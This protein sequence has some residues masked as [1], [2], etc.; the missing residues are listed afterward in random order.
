MKQESN[1]SD[2]IKNYIT[3]HYTQINIKYIIIR[4]PSFDNYSA[5][6]I[7]ESS[8]FYFFEFPNLWHTLISEMENSQEAI[9][10]KITKKIKFQL[11]QFSNSEYRRLISILDSEF[12][13]RSNTKKKSKFMDG[14]TIKIYSNNK[15]FFKKYRADVDGDFYK[16]IE[17]IMSKWD[18]LYFN[19]KNEKIIEYESNISKLEVAE[20]KNNRNNT[21]IDVDS[22]DFKLTMESLPHLIDLLLSGKMKERLKTRE[23]RKDLISL[24]QDFDPLLIKNSGITKIDIKIRPLSFPIKNFKKN[25]YIK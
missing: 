25:K 11:R 22:L 13:S 1:Y 15:K 20:F 16:I 5:Y 19:V 12:I 2:W 18:F 17:D 8:N 3:T 14:T 23:G 21:N 10:K 9:I 7:T 24:L 4:L 6:V